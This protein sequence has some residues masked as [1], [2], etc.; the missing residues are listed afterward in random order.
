MDSINGVLGILISAVKTRFRHF[1]HHSLARRV[2][3][4]R[5]LA[6][7]TDITATTNGRYEFTSLGSGTPTG[8]GKGEATAVK[9]R[10]LANLLERLKGRVSAPLPEAVS[11]FYERK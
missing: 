6:A 4:R 3:A 7:V 10:H 9:P 5:V 1:S 11:C 8:G 2:P